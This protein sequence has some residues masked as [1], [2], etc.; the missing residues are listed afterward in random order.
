MSRIISMSLPEDTLQQL[1]QLTREQNW[2]GRSETIRQGLRLLQQEHKNRTKVTGNIHAILSVIHAPQ[3]EV[4][5]L[6][7]EYQPII[8]THL[9][10]HLN[11]R[12]CLDVFVLKGDATRIRKLVNSLE[13][14]KKVHQV[15]LDPIE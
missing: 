6:T 11:D 9:H 3:R 7:H 2:S 13:R 14:D 10:N 12:H 4:A 15:K 5:A 1:D 8:L